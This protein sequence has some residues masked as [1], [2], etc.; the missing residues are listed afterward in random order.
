MALDDLEKVIQNKYHRNSKGNIQN[1]FHA[2]TK[3]NLVKY[4]DDFII[5]ANSRQIAKELK[6]V[7]NS[8]LKSMKDYKKTKQH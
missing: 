6:T 5:T 2:K 8:F 7:V 1:H 3:I 4:A